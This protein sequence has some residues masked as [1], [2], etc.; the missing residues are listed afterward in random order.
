MSD[1][2]LR[3]VGEFNH[4]EYV[5]HPADGVLD[6]SKVEGGLYKTYIHQNNVWTQRIHLCLLPDT[7]QIEP[8]CT[9]T[10]RAL[11]QFVSTGVFAKPQCSLSQVNRAGRFIRD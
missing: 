10:G 3:L 8:F 11:I 2:G 9:V 7:I 1:Y 6:F 4:E 5:L